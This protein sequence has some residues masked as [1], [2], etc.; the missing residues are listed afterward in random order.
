M[1][2]IIN[3]RVIDYRIASGG[4]PTPVQISALAEAGC[5][6]VINLAL[7]TSTHAIANEGELVTRLGLTYIHIP[8]VWEKPTLDDF[9]QFVGVMQ[10]YQEKKIFVHC[11]MNMRASCFLYLYRLIVEGMDPEIAVYDMLSV[12]QP[13]ETWQRFMDEVLSHYA[14]AKEQTN[15]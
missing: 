14:T 6:V 2:H 4:Q 9:Q 8:V 10:I 5:Q 7:P 1:E 11:A 15:D 12:F 13:N 3:F